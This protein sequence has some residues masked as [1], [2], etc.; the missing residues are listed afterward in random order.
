MAYY[1][2][3]PEIYL[4]DGYAQSAL[5]N[6]LTGEIIA[7]DSI[8]SDV[9]KSIENNTSCDQSLVIDELIKCNWAE[10]VNSPIFVDKIRYSNAF[11]KNRFWK[12]FPQLN[13]IIL[14]ITNR[15]GN[16]CGNHQCK[17][18][19]C[20]MCMIKGK[21]NEMSLESAHRI[22]NLLK[23]YN[24]KLFIITGGN[25]LI[26]SDFEKIYK[27]VKS[28]GIKTYIN[29]CSI[30]HIDDAFTDV[31]LILSVSNERDLYNFIQKKDNYPNLD[32]FINSNI[33]VILPEYKR[34]KD[35]PIVEKK[36]LEKRVTFGEFFTRR[37]YDSCLCGKITIMSNGDVIPCF[38]MCEKIL[39]NCLRDDFETILKDLYDDYWSKGVDDW[40]N[41]CVLCPYRYNCRS[42]RKYSSSNCNY[43]LESSTWR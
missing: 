24:P 36:D 23:K 26:H 31:P 42:C 1:R 30:E 16:E 41:N 2:L 38:G 15:C 32:V 43:N 17:K 40:N 22:V 25:P 10:K 12:S 14:Q 34:F 8:E 21:K 3:K 7:L 39:G 4:I 28:C 5:V 37:S 29:L 19:F 33:S 13:A 6:V 27:I 18:N 11:N 35:P 20:P 9:V